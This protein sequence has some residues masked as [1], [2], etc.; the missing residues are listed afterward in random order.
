MKNKIIIFSV[1]LLFTGIWAIN[2]QQ[3]QDEKKN[4]Y[5]NQ[6]DKSK[7]SVSDAQWKKVLA[8]EV[9]DIMREKGTE[10]AGTGPY[11]HNYKKGMYYCAS[12]GNLLFSAD[13]K[14]DSH[15]GW[16]SFFQPLDNGSVV[17]AKDD[18]YGMERDEIRCAR[19]GG[20]L[21]HVF[22]DGPKPTGLRY[23]MNGYA[24]NFVPA[25]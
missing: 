20:H 16:P 6:T 12:C 15:T 19:C 24:L 3:A 4:P 25:K 23:C 7:V 21:G 17:Q 8:P 18:S 10:R 13:T 11:V 1:L 22:D 2:A 5:Y 9:Y 14:F